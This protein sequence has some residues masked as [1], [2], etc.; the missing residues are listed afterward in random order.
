MLITVTKS[1]ESLY[2]ML[3]YVY[4]SKCGIYEQYHKKMLIT[5]FAVCLHVK[6]YIAA[7]VS[8]LIIH[9]DGKK[10]FISKSV[11]FSLWISVLQIFCLLKTGI[12]PQIAQ[13]A[14]L[15]LCSLLSW[16]IYFIL[17]LRWAES[18]LYSLIIASFNSSEI[19]GLGQHPAGRISYR[20][21]LLTPNV[22]AG[23]LARDADS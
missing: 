12:T 7:E 13:L 9:L 10:S 1:C 8:V 11:M 20:H 16:F 21:F 6:N 18:T 3:T 14:A 19:R 17:F 22:A 4:H 23:A 5:Y 15:Q 2:V